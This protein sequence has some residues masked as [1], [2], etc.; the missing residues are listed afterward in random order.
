[1]QFSSD[2]VISE[3]NLKFE[4]V[5]LPFH[6]DKITG[7]D[8][9]VRKALVATCSLD[10]TVRIWNYIDNTLEVMK[11]FEEEA[12]ALAFHPSGFHVIVAFVDKIRLLNIFE[13][14]I[15]CFKELPIKGCKE[16]SFSNGGHLFAITNASV[17]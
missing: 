1:V 11:E 6:S 9:C 16:I 3:E 8:V 15:V 7:M 12:S 4:P 13:H 17:V 5:F 2:R 10:K 14:D